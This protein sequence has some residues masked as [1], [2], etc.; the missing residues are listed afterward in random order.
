MYTITV[1]IH[2]STRA[3]QRNTTQS[4]NAKIYGSD[5]CCFPLR[6]DPK[7]TLSMTNF[8]QYLDGFHVVTRRSVH[9]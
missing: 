5:T 4:E 1:H 6:F 2:D 7:V 8:P 9:R 3:V